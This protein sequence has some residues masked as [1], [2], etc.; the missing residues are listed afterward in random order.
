MFTSVEKEL[1]G[2][3]TLT[4]ALA[5]TGMILCKQGHIFCFTSESST[6]IKSSFGCNSFNKHFT[7]PLIRGGGPI[8]CLRSGS[9]AAH[10]DGIGDESWFCGFWRFVHASKYWLNITAKLRHKIHQC[11]NLSP[12]TV[13]GTEGVKLAVTKL[14]VSRYVIQI[15]IHKRPKCSEPHRHPVYHILTVWI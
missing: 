9:G 8:H 7:S 3:K 6:I 13:S 12:L 4:V 10:V 14:S 15:R 1:E 5:V 11:Y 2:M